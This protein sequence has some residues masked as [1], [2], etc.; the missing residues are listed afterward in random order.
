MLKRLLACLALITGLT[1]AGAPANASVVE[2]LSCEIGVAAFDA[3]DVAEDQRPCPADE[4]ANPARRP[5]TEK[6]PVKR[7]KRGW[8]PPVLYGIDRAYE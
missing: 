8:R 2:A 5:D 3:G 4:A 1:A 6:P 7:S